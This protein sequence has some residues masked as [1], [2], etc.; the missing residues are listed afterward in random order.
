MTA[1]AS[2]VLWHTTLP[3]STRLAEQAMGWMQAT[4]VQAGYVPHPAWDTWS[5]DA[6]R[7]AQRTWAAVFAAL[8]SAVPDMGSITPWTML[9]GVGVGTF[10]WFALLSLAASVLGRFTGP[11]F[12]R[13]VDTAAAIGLLAFAAVLAWQ[14]LAS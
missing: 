1:P 3:T 13:G 7:Y 10:T 11:R 2:L 9:A 6:R 8:S 12:H 14:V 4:L 5:I